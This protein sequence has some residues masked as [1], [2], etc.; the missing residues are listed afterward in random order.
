MLCVNFYIIFKMVDIFLHSRNIFRFKIGKQIF[1][2]YILIFLSIFTVFTLSSQDLTFENINFNK[3]LKNSDITSIAQ[4]KYGN[5]WFGT[6]VGLYKYDGVSSKNYTI[7][8]NKPFN[9]KSNKITGIF[10]LKSGDLYVTTLLEGVF[11]YNYET[12]NFTHIREES[13]QELLRNNIQFLYE[14]Q[15]NDIWVATDKGI[16]IIYKDSSNIKNHI[17]FIKSTVD[18]TKVLHITDANSP[19]IW[20]S[21]KNG[22]Y[23]FYKGKDKTLDQ[24]WHFVFDFDQY[25]S[26]QDNYINQVFPISKEKFLVLSKSGLIEIDITNGFSKASV[27]ISEKANNEFV[28]P[29]LLKKSISFQN[30]GLIGTQRGLFLLDEN[31]KIIQKSFLNNIPIRTIFTDTFGMIWIGTESGLYTC[32]PFKQNVNSLDFGRFTNVSAL[33]VHSDPYTENVW[34][35]WQNGEISVSGLKN[36]AKE[37]IPTYTLSTPDGKKNTEKI[38]QIISTPDGNIYVS[39]HGNGVLAFKNPSLSTNLKKITAFKK[40]SWSHGLTDDYVMSMAYYKQQL[41]LGTYNK[42][43]FVYDPV[44][45][46]VLEA[47]IDQKTKEILKTIPV[48]KLMVTPNN[49]LI[50]ATRGLGLFIFKIEGFNLI[51]QRHFNEAPENGAI[52]SNFI[53]DFDIYGHK[54]WIAN[55]GGVDIIDLNLQK[56]VQADLKISTSIVQS[57]Q[58]IS[59]TSALI[60]TVNG[61]IQKLLFIDHQFLLQNY[62]NNTLAFYN[63]SCKTVL[64]NHQIL[65]GGTGGVSLVNHT[66]LIMNTKPPFININDFKIGN[67]TVHPNQKIHGKVKFEKFAN[68][69]SIINLSYL[70]RSV[71]FT[72]AGLHSI[73]Q[74]QIKIAYKIDKLQDEWIILDKNSNVV[75]LTSLPPGT[76]N[77]IYKATIDEVNWSDEKTLIIHVSPPWYKSKIAYFI[78]ML[79]ILITLGGIILLINIKNNYDNK[80]KFQNLEKANL[81]EMDQLKM[82]FYTSVSHELRTPLTMILTPLQQ[83]INKKGGHPDPETLYNF[84][85][86]NATKL[87]SMIDKLLSFKPNN[88]NLTE[89][90]LVDVDILQYIKELVSDFSLV[91]EEKNI[92]IHF[93]S[94]LDKLMMFIDLDQIEIVINN[95]ISNALKYSNPGK[96]IFVKANTVNDHLELKF[97]DEGIGIHPKDITKVF[98]RFYQ[99]RNH[100]NAGHGLGLSI[101]KNIITLHKG[102]IEVQSKINEGTVFTILLPIDLQSTPLPLS[103]DIIIKNS[104]SIKAEYNSNAFDKKLLI[105]EDNEDIR[106]LL[107]NYFQN[108]YEVNFAINGEEGYQ[109]ALQENPDIIISDIAMEPVDGFEL[110]QKIKANFETSHIP[111]ILLTARTSIEYQMMGY[112][113]GANAYVTKPFNLDLLSKQVKNLIEYKSII[114]ASLNSV[115]N[116]EDSLQFTSLSFEDTIDN[117]FI[118]KLIKTIEDNL[119]N[120]DYTLDNLSKDLLI[121]K[122]NLNR[123]IKA[124]TGLT[125]NQYIRKFKLNAAA[126][127]LEKSKYSIAEITYK[128]GFN[129]LK[130]FREIFKEEFGST[131]SEFR[132]DY[133]SNESTYK[134]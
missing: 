108:E 44:T 89:L 19:Y 86:K 120:G 133:Q 129:D 94:K 56:K 61:E 114:Q 93:I 73:Y 5:L 91:A 115:S 118:Q 112:E 113:Y 12:D 64:N 22:V 62:K 65:F 14:D 128:V 34:I 8:Y 116:H 107:I 132:E 75:N 119:E 31:Y 109:K 9:L 54:L 127:Y 28:F 3:T 121:S 66:Q 85:Y 79:M 42:G 38:S 74:D 97:I 29:L 40:I 102:T 103:K 105:V 52:S 39:T 36:L 27:T 49:H 41:F 101:V 60:S 37:I 47:S 81:E 32:S 69:N 6:W 104:T 17:C 96:Q 68:E 90:N 33:C 67:Q 51:F 15:D 100:S 95:L 123:K 76:F 16:G 35:G 7:D 11:K 98:D 126:K 110:T 23:V 124:L 117:Q 83:L 80:I 20:V 43:L 72:F 18:V 130:Y 53:T 111:I 58:V 21:T 77:L 4:D 45:D 57:I 88:S 78:Y 92:N 106:N 63:S 59:D 87:K 71:S 84:M 70:D 26:A 134:S 125:P 82:R 13:S 2:K 48:I 25:S 1:V 30:Y 46:R 131:P 122:I 55:E 50:V 99:G 24:V 10:K